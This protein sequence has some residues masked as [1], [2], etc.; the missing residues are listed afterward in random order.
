MG[1][2]N[3]HR[4]R[5][6]EFL[7]ID[8]PRLPLTG[9]MELFRTLA[10]LGGEPVALHLLESPKLDKAITQLTGGT[11][12]KGQ[13]GSIRGAWPSLIGMNWMSPI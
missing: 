4:S 8:F 3:R 2:C 9:N 1:S 12:G 10:R 7:K 13:V 5:Y 6:A 11:S